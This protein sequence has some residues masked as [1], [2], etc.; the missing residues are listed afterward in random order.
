MPSAYYL[1]LGSGP[2]QLLGGSR[3]RHHM[4]WIKLESFW[5]GNE[6]HPSGATAGV[7]TGKATSPDIVVSKTTD[8]ASTDIFMAANDARVFRSAMI[9]IADEKSGVPKVRLTLTDVMLE[10]FSVNANATV[11]QGQSERFKLVFRGAEW[12][13]NPI[14]EESVGDILQT[15]FWSLGLA[16]AQ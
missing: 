4:G 14:A 13:H 10:H 11:S 7:G 15:A 8:R 3:D 1:K 2:D 12:N 16:R 5:M 9:E 6:S